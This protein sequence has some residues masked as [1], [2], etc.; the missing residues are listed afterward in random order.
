MNR[1]KKS[2]FALFLI[3][4]SCLFPV[5]IAFFHQDAVAQTEP[6]SFPA[7]ALRGTLVVQTPPDVLLD[8]H[9]DRL[10]PGAR[11]RDTRNL[12]AMSASLVGHELTVNYV[13]DGAGLIHEV[14]ILSAEET[15]EKRAGQGDG[16]NFQFASEAD[17]AKRDDG[18]TP[19][20]QLPVYPSR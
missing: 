3:A 7:K 12:L 16:R 17:N 9:A 14:W 1:C 11:I 18:K 6:R 15:R 8:G 13:R 20:N 2:V 10:S 19:F 4:T 5:G